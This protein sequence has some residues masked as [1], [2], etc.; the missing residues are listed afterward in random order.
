MSSEH[1][2]KKL[3]IDITSRTDIKKDF[4]PNSDERKSKSSS[5]SS[6]ENDPSWTTAKI[7]DELVTELALA[8]V[9]TEN[10]R[11]GFADIVLKYYE[12]GG[13]FDV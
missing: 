11:F 12:K 7:T 8:S 5:D 6:R 10:H 3:P 13:T 9:Y 2:E 1:R 4:G